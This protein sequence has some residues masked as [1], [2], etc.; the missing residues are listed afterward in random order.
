M[1]KDEASDPQRMEKQ[2][3]LQIPAPLELD[4]LIQKEETILH[5]L[6]ALVKT[7]KK[8]STQERKQGAEPHHQ[9]EQ[10]PE[11][12][13]STT[14]ELLTQQQDK[15]M[16]ILRGMV[17]DEDLEYNEQDGTTDAVLK[18]Q[19]L[20][21]SSTDCTSK[22]KRRELKPKDEQNLASKTLSSSSCGSITRKDEDSTVL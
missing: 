11:H 2:T 18:I 3:R 5:M 12:N 8:A 20:S 16:K 19:E 17:N 7:Q 10:S 22:R 4:R 9:A 15:M 21:S 14:L 6:H 1:A 13:E